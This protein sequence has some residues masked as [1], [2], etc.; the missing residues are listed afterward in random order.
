MATHNGAMMYNIC[1]QTYCLRSLAPATGQGS[2]AKPLGNGNFLSQKEAHE[3][4]QT[5]GYDGLA[6]L[7]TIERQESATKIV[8]EITLPHWLGG[9]DQGNQVLWKNAGLHNQVLFKP[10]WHAGQPNDCDGPGS[11]TCMFIGPNGDWFDFACA[12]K[13][14]SKK[15]TGH[16]N[17]GKSD[18]GQEVARNFE[19]SR[20]QEDTGKEDAGQEKPSKITAGPEIEW[21][22]GSN[23]KFEYNVYPLCGMVMK[24]K[25]D[26]DVVTIEVNGDGE[27]IEEMDTMEL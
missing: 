27:V 1:S 10:P 17:M 4:C 11:E 7:N 18:A 3:S 16:E 25:E 12:P 21:V 6:E 23:N 22:A 15:D 8:R 24:P 26:N 2:I 9:F 5:A 14:P 20:Y 19:I 13:I